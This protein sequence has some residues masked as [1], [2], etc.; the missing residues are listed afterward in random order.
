[1]TLSTGLCAFLITSSFLGEQILNMSET[2]CVKEN[3]GKLV[4]Q[5]VTEQC[6]N[7]AERE[8]ELVPEEPRELFHTHR[9]GLF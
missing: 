4:V 8:T 3:A 9:S 2:N 5:S 6:S 7:A 1:M